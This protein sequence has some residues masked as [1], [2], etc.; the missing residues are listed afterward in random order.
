MTCCSINTEPKETREETEAH[1]T[2]PAL[3]HSWNRLYLH[4][5]SHPPCQH[6]GLPPKPKLV[7]LSSQ[8]FWPSKMEP[9]SLGGDELPISGVIQAKAER[10]RATALQG[11]P[12]SIRP[13]AL[14]LMQDGRQ[15]NTDRVQT[16][17]QGC[18]LEGECDWGEPGGGAERAALPVPASVPAP[19]QTRRLLLPSP[20]WAPPP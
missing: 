4:P 18:H 5:L 20:G 16:G 2:P 1:S 11:I 19:T 9:V 14:D 6:L 12:K 13:A 3:I 17:K 10:L 7:L 15:A 8:P